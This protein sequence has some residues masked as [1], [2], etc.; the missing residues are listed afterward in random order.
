M[1]RRMRTLA[2]RQVLAPGSLH[3]TELATDKCSDVATA[4]FPGIAMRNK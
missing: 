4:N 1:N 3:K 2:Y